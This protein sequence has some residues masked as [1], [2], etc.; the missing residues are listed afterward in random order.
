MVQNESPGAWRDAGRTDANET[1]ANDLGT[2]HRPTPALGQTIAITERGQFLGYL[3]EK[4]HGFDA[5]TAQGFELGRFN[6]AEAGAR[7]LWAVSADRSRL[8]G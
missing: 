3:A 6:T 1:V 8:C 2:D 4:R 5:V 7:A